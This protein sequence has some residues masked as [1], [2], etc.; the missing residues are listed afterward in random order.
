MN[1]FYGSEIMN[2]I[3]NEDLNLEKRTIPLIT[4]F[5][6]SMDSKF[7][8]EFNKPMRFNE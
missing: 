5:E 7:T 8:F 2:K 4:K 6:I 1:A 3:S